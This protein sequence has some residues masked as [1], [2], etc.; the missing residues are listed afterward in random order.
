[1]A[2]EVDICNLSL[3][4]ISE[5]ANVQSISPPDASVAAEKCA[6]FYPIARDFLLEAHTWSFNTKR[7]LLALLSTNPTVTW[8]YGYSLPSDCIRPV[9]VYPYGVADDTESEDFVV[10]TQ[11]NGDAVLYT[12]VEQ[13]ELKYQIRVTATIR[14]TP[15]FVTT[16]SWLLSSYLAGAV[17]KGRAGAA[18]AKQAFE[19]FVGEFGMASASNAGASQLR[20]AMKD[21]RPVWISDR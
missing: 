20:N 14:F 1:M 19:R 8:S 10:E 9:A 4:N 21:R 15:M 7:K 3:S 11:E 18:V 12:N 5:E 17:I 13:A 2:T 6:Q 16:L